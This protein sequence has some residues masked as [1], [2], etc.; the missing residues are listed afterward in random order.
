MT[1]SCNLER[2]EA[3][4]TSPLKRNM[5]PFFLQWL[6][7]TDNCGGLVESVSKFKGGLIVKLANITEHIHLCIKRTS[8]DIPVH[9]HNECYDF[10]R[11]IDID[12]RVDKGGMCYC[13]L[14]R[15][16]VRL[17][18]TEYD[19]YVDHTFSQV[20]EY[21]ESISQPGKSLVLR[22]RVN[23]YSDARIIDSASIPDLDREDVTLIVD[24]C[25]P[26][27]S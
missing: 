10:L 9:F 21:L 5:I 1:G 11:S 13:A 23:S 24:V 17:Y 4:M 3:D 20:R 16:D 26:K 19:L 12:A 2:M 7:E 14:C 27:K 22:Y 6:R 15:E 25:A 18:E 8:F